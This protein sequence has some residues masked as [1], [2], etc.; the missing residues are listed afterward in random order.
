VGLIIGIS[1]HSENLEYFHERAIAALRP[2]KAVFRV[3]ISA[4]ID[5]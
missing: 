2:A 1:R 4:Q 3:V 5:S